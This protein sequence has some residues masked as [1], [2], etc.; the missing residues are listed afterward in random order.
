MKELTVLHGRKL[1]SCS[2]KAMGGITAGSSST[3]ELV[4]SRYEIKYDIASI[5]DYQSINTFLS[6]DSSYIPVYEH[7]YGILKITSLSS[8]LKKSAGK[9]ICCC[10]HFI[11]NKI[12]L[13]V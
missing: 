13:T 1:I 10:N 9:N 4:A 6:S 7:G 8:A 12:S 2:F 3:A 11:T 5:S